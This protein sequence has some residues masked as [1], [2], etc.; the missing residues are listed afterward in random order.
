MNDT[1]L[2]F[3]ATAQKIAFVCSMAGLFYLSRTGANLAAARAFGQ[4]SSSLTRAQR[5]RC[6]AE[7]LGARRAQG[8]A[9]KRPQ[10]IHRGEL[11]FM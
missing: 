11:G 3:Q 10:P 2:V 1:S 9:G 8:E 7:A 5:W 4:V 6:P